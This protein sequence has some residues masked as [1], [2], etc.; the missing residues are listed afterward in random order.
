[1]KKRTIKPKLVVADDECDSQEF[2]RPRSVKL[3]VAVLARTCVKGMIPKINDLTLTVVSL[4]MIV[5][6]VI[7]TLESAN[8]YAW[9]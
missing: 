4:A 3:K 1:M 5:S 2:L 6:Y 7:M 8:K 9:R